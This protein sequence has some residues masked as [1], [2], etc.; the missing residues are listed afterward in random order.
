M[1]FQRMNLASY[2]WEQ[3]ERSGLLVPA[4]MDDTPASTYCNAASASCEPPTVEELKA[5][6]DR[7][8]RP[9]YEMVVTTKTIWDQLR[10]HPQFVAEREPP[11]WQG[12]DCYRVSGIPVEVYPGNVA[13][14]FRSEKL[15]KDGKRVMLVLEKS[16]ESPNAT[17]P[18]A[19]TSPENLQV[20]LGDGD[21]AMG[22]S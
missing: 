15:K 10:E 7:F 21:F 5:I 2:V 3:C 6:M 11:T 20:E 14:Y 16:V 17:L 9:E 4:R 19:N 13:A 1:K 18:E 8:P 22:D 12:L